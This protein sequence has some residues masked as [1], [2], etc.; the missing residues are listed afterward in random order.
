MEEILACDLG[1]NAIFSTFSSCFPIHLFK[2][3][4]VKIFFS[5]RII[6]HIC[7]LHCFHSPLSITNDIQWSVP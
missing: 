1:A 3:L 5:C 7:F 2:Y 6:V 4:R